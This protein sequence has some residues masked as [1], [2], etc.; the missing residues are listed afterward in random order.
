MKLSPILALLLA[1]VISTLGIVFVI[2]T[3]PAATPPQPIPATSPPS[4]EHVEV[5]LRLEPQKT[6]VAIGEET[7][8]QVILDTGSIGAAIV[9][10]T[11]TFDPKK[12][13]IV[14]VAPGPFLDKPT[15]LAHSVDEASGRLNYALGS[16][17]YQQGEG[18]VFTVTVK[19]TAPTSESMPL[20]AF[21]RTDTQVGLKALDRH[22]VYSPEETVIIFEEN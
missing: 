6:Q 17:T 22:K 5:T 13:T 10:T 12:L 18:V 4:R 7:T 15:V 14:S 11:L 9:D 2:R 3:L 8:Y 16:L 21:D 19:V 1:I 20:V